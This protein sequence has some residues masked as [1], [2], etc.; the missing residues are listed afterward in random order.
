MKN[1]NGPLDN[2]APDPCNILR[3]ATYDRKAGR[4]DEA[5]EK[6]SWF[7]QNAVA[8][9]PLMYGIRRSFAISSWCK[10]AEKFPP[11][12]DRLKS[13]RQMA[14]ENVMMGV[15]VVESFRDLAAISERLNDNK[16][17]CSIFHFLHEEQ[18]ANATLVYRYAQAALVAEAEYSI[19][20]HYLDSN[21]ATDILISKY[22]RL[23]SARQAISEQ[24]QRSAKRQLVRSAGTIVALLTVNEQM[25]KATD[26]ARRFSDVF[27]D[28]YSQAVMQSSLRGVFPNRYSN[29]GAK[30]P[31]GRGEN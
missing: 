18:P 19:C 12:I 22:H 26:L 4:Y 1:Y 13:V 20:N 15:E 9:N 10:L 5:L 16:T 25:N 27:G 30:I 14:S 3:E 17:V 29:R 2:N 21:I 6:L 8:V 24:R 23:C 31:F 11:A 28:S 7:F